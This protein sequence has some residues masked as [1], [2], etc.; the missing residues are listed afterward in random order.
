MPAYRTRNV[1]EMARGI[2]C[3][4]ELNLGVTRGQIPAQA[5]QQDGNKVRDL[6][7]QL[8]SSRD[9]VSEKDKRISRLEKQLSVIRHVEHEGI[10]LPP[11]HLRPNAKE[12]KNDNQVYLDSARREV[13]WMVGNLG[14]T[15]ESSV[16]DL[17]CGPG[18]T[19]IGI[20]DRVGEIKKYR[21]VDVN[22]RYVRWA[23]HHITFEHP[24]FQFHHLNL[25]NDHYNPEGAEIASDVSFPFEDGEFDVI[26]L[27]S[28]FTH[29]MTEDVRRY[30]KELR[31]VLHPSGR[32][33]M[34]ANLADGVPDVTENPEGYRGRKKYIMRLET[35]LYNREFFE[36]LIEESG[37]HLEG[38]DPSVK[39]GQSCL[40]VSKKANEK[41]AS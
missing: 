4:L 5:P 26:Y 1:I 6:Q 27:F 9:E 12:R 30:L 18:R 40:I 25:K 37:L 17:G 33:F 2:K 31:R 7:Q 39:K 11:A 14:L 20:L 16:L 22:E 34:T 41:L 29:M 21:G 23:Q 10:A 8:K 36:G 13:D 15:R 32:I 19:A 3:F 38:Y 24:N 35:V 28:V